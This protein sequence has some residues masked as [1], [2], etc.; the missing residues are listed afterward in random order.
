MPIANQEAPITL[1]G[2]GPFENSVAED[3]MTQWGGKDGWGGI[4]RVLIHF[5]ESPQPNAV[6]SVIAVAAAGLI[7]ACSGLL[8][9]QNQKIVDTLTLCGP[10][11]LDLIRTAMLAMT[12]VQLRS[13][14]KDLWSRDLRGPKWL[15]STS[16]L[17]VQLI[18]LR[19]K[20]MK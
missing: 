1:A 5:T 19:R 12:G 14:L 4:S 11:P 16:K 18:E 2:I 8:K 9:C 7:L 17:Q 10:A 3:W 6:D 20:R 15:E 13:G